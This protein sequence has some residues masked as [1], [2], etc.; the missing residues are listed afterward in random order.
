MGSALLLGPQSP[1]RDAARAA[2]ETSG[3]HILD[4]SGQPASIGFES[5]VAGAPPYLL[6]FVTGHHCD[7]VMADL[8]P[9]AFRALE[10]SMLVEPWTALREAALRLTAPGSAV[11]LAA[12]VAGPPGA[13]GAFAAAAQRALRTMVAAA[14][15]EFAPRQNAL[16]VNL[17]EYDAS[18]L[19]VA[20]LQRAVA[21]F[22]APE[23]GFMTG[24]HLSVPAARARLVDPASAAGGAR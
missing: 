9:E 3:W 2:L 4:A 20:A 22:A 23:S 19:D 8:S 21:F 7:G 13:R 16:R 6:V 5:L 14:A 1:A 15:V 17:L 11:L 24:S 12:D 10:S 18:R